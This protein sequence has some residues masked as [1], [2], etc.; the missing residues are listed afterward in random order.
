MAKVVTFRRGLW[1]QLYIPELIRG[2]GVTL[3]HFFVNTFT[4]RDIVTMRYP[5]ETVEYPERNR[6]VHR[7]MLREDG[8]VRC[9][10]CMMCSTVCPAHCIHIEAGERDDGSGIEKYPVK[11]DIDEL[12]CVVCGLCVEACPCDAIRMDGGQHMPPVEHRYQA[13]L[14]KDD[15]K[16]RGTRSIAVQ[17]GIGPDWKE[18]SEPVLGDV[19]AI[20]DR[21]DR[22]SKHLKGS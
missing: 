17:G 8:S 1:E 6:G 9:V 21:N 12:V 7:L 4:K 10:A 13:Y 15:L 3:R 18:K 20:Y 22:Y 14:E 5:E 19:R 11:F 2:M 16:N